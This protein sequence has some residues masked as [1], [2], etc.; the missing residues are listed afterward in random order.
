M[1]QPGKPIKGVVAVQAAHNR[2]ETLWDALKARHCY[3]TTG[4]RIIM[5]LTI[6]GQPMGSEFKAQMGDAL[7]IRFEVN[8]S[9]ELSFVELVRYRF[10][11]QMWETVHIDRTM[12]RDPFAE[13]GIVDPMDYVGHLEQAFEGDVLYYLRVGQKKQLDNWP[14]LGWSSPIWVTATQ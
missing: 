11:Q 3:G 13:S 10:D 12:V 7:D 8:G 1:G 6:N 2:R 4:E 9:D 14:V 5:E